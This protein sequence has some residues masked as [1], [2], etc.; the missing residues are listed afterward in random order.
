MKFIIALGVFF[1]LFISVN[2]QS[3]YVKSLEKWRADHEA[4]LKAENGWLTVDGRTI[5]RMEDFR[6]T[7]D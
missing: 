3:E 6:V 2:A 4:K 7:A 5:Y 1:A